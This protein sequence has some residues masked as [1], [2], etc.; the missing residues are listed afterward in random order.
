[1]TCYN[2]IMERVL[3]ILSDNNKGRFIAKGYSD[4]FKN[5][6]Y[7]VYERKIKDLNTDEIKNLNCDIIFIFWSDLHQKED[8]VNVLNEIE[9]EKCI[10]INC[11][12]RKD[13]ILGVILNKKNSFNFHPR[14]D[15]YD[16]IPGVNPSAYKAKFDKY[17]Y[18]ISFSGNPAQHNR[19]VTLSKLIYKFGSLNIFCRSFDFYKSL[20]EISQKKLLD[21]D[22]IEL[23]KNSYRGYA[24]S[25][26]E[27]SEIYCSSEINIDLKNENK[28]V[29]NY[30]IFE[31][32]ASGGFLLTP[33]SQ[34]STKYFENGKE[35]ET[36][37]SD[38]DLIDKIEFYKKNLNLAQMIAL[39]SRKNTAS[40]HTFDDR[41]K[42]ILK[43]IYGK[44]ING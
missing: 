3:I 30:R 37:V 34:D 7:F 10:T 9:N 24:E 12:E 18:S 33:F 42:V 17:K 14:N 6:S 25:S 13:D 38:S 20:D 28:D 15:K 11:A 19:E 1:M 26:K 41:L 5:L 2:N 21:N 8:V 31:I 23:Y 39:N 32:S 27:L 29:L 44:N 35:I 22:F 36:Y 4:A 40:N 43:A 16:Y